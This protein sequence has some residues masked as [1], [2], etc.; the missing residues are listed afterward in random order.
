MISDIQ[1][2]NLTEHWAGLVGLA[3][4]ALAYLLAIGEE[5][6]QLRKSKPAI[7]AAGIIW[8]V[9]AIAYMEHGDTH[10]PEQILR[11]G[12]EYYTELFLFLLA[13]M[14]FVNAMGERQVFRVLSHYLVSQ[15]SSLRG[16]Y[17]L[18]GSATFLLS[19]LANNLT[20]ALLMA[21]VVVA[22]GRKERNFVFAGCMSVV[23][24]ANAGG[25]FS[26][27]G[28]VTTLLIWQRG[29]LEFH[30]FFQLYLPALVT[31]LIP[32][33]CLSVLVP[34]TSPE[35]FQE[36]VAL[37]PG[38]GVIVGLFVLAIVMAVTVEHFLHMPAVLGMMTGLGFLKLYGYHLKRR[39]RASGE[40][41]DEF[42]IFRSLEHAE[43]DTLMFFFGILISISGL[44]AL[45]YL[46]LASDFLYG[47]LNTTTANI[48]VGLLSAVIE[49]VPVM[50]SVLGMD[51]D[52]STGQ[53]LLV[54]L[55]TGIGGSLLAIGSA[56][57]IAVMGEARGIYTFYAHLKWSWAVA[58]G[59]AAGIGLHL[60][61]NS[62]TFS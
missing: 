45:G 22:I 24:A 43:W 29:L 61:L 20:T 37:L 53:W 50:F 47:N 23:V 39:Q 56:A 59:Y 40:Q 57:G 34:K 5:S 55:T 48:L 10:T 60:F 46:A 26:P 12:I 7:V 58:L 15:G 32:A 1:V 13:A 2:L 41:Q 62:A 38:A 18:I 3:V 21:T 54:T 27:F 51:L 8:L 33:L 14:T 17:W 9:V 44:A 6:L 28:D 25:A 16:V 4:F 35:P 49:N 42:D 30:E 36:K 52:M 31:W 19:S 11:R